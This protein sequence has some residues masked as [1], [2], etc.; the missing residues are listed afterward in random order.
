LWLHPQSLKDFHS[1]PVFAYP[2]ADNVPEAYRDNPQTITQENRN[3]LLN[4]FPGVDGL[5]T[6]YIDEAGYNI[7]LTAE[8]DN[9]RFI[10]VILGAPAQP[11][12]I[13]IRNADSV[14]LLSWAFDN[15]KTVRPQIDKIENARLWKGR[16]N[17]AELQFEYSPDFTSPIN[18]GDK[19][20]FETVIPYPL[21]APLPVGYPA[22]YLSISDEY[23]ELYRVPLVTV[24]AY[25]KGNIFKRLWHSILLL[26][27][28]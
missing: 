2:L 20:F 19:L 6:G 5:K 17:T 25:E 27:Q 16:A 28:S 26:F 14:N 4:R 9:T 8:R 3:A 23:G 11:G 13:N 15:F 10:A 18:R 22:G 24:R 7:A 12:G 1:V 21:K